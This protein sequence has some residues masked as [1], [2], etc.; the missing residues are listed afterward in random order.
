MKTSHF[1][2]LMLSE[3]SLHLALFNLSPATKQVAP[4][5]KRLRFYRAAPFSQN[6]SLVLLAFV[7]GCRWNSQLMKYNVL[8]I[9]SAKRFTCGEFIGMYAHHVSSDQDD[10]L[11][12]GWLVASR[13]NTCK[14]R[15][16]ELCYNPKDV[17]A[18]TSNFFHFPLKKKVYAK[19]LLQVKDYEVA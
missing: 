3:L 9:I 1:D 7:I 13:V 17:G 18:E 8:W 11:I 6:M 4:F 10:N 15:S 12:A 5:F 19:M 16:C 14:C 2:V